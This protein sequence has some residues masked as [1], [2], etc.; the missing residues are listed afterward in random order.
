M[1]FSN[2]VA[3]NVEFESFIMA[4]VA[5]VEYKEFVNEHPSM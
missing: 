4:D 2:G 5:D 3:S 1:S